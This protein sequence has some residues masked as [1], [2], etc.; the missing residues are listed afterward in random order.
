MTIF[1]TDL[2]NK[3]KSD[4]ARDKCRDFSNLVTKKD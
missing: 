4:D 1:L 3:L 2:V